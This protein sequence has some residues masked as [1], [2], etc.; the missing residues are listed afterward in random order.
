MAITTLF[1]TLVPVL[2]GRF[3]LHCSQMVPDGFLHDPVSYA[4]GLVFLMPLFTFLTNMGNRA[5]RNAAVAAAAQMHVNVPPP[6]PEELQ[7]RAPI[8]QPLLPDTLTGGLTVL[9]ELFSPSSRIPIRVQW[10]GTFI[11]LFLIH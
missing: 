11:P 2:M 4:M 7:L 6:P 5:A 1:I 9:K 8:D 10:I 3:S